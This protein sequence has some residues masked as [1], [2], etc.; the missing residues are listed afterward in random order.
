MFLWAK[1][2][3]ARL[4]LVRVSFNL[5]NRIREFR[6]G[7][8][9]DQQVL[10]LIKQG[11][12]ALN[13]TFDDKL[14]LVAAADGSLITA[15]SLCWHLM[16]PAR[17]EETLPDLVAVP[18]DIGR[19]LERVFRELRLKYREAVAAFTS[20]DDRAE[21]ACI[22]LLLALA[23]EPEAYCTSTPTPTGILARPR[24][25]RTR[26]PARSARPPRP[27]RPS[28]GSSTTTPWAAA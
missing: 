2:T 1:Y 20:L 7:W 5:A 16:V 3:T 25:P 17:I 14:A 10:G 11:E 21:S 27:V 15:Q 24:R 6:L 23:A 8:A 28:A 26:W 19:A 12:N 13:I 9:G 18:T 4:S 22:D